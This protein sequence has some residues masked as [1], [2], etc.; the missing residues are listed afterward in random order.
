MGELLIDNRKSPEAQK[1]LD[2]KTKR[3]ERFD[4]ITREFEKRKYINNMDDFMDIA[5]NQ[6]FLA[7]EAVQVSSNPILPLEAY[8]EKFREKY[9]ENLISP[10]NIGNTL[11]I[12][13]LVAKQNNEEWLQIGDYYPKLFGSLIERI[14]DANNGR[15]TYPASDFFHLFND[16]EVMDFAISSH[17]F[18]F[19]N[20]TRYNF[21]KP[22][23][24]DTT[25]PLCRELKKFSDIVATRFAFFSS[26]ILPEPLKFIQEL[27][28]LSNKEIL[29]NL[30][31]VKE[32]YN[33]NNFEITN[34]AANCYSNFYYRE[35]MQKK[36]AQLSKE[37][38]LLINSFKE[39]GIHKGEFGKIFS[40]NL[41][42]SYTTLDNSISSKELIDKR[43]L[44][45]YFDFFIA[46]DMNIAIRNLTLIFTPENPN[47]I[48][49]RLVDLFESGNIL[50]TSHIKAE[51][52]FKRLMK[53]DLSDYEFEADYEAKE[54]RDFYKFKD[55]KVI[56]NVTIDDSLDIYGYGDRVGLWNLLGGDA[57]QKPTSFLQIYDTHR[58]L[59][60][61]DVDNLARTIL[62]FPFLLERFSEFIYPN[63]LSGE[64]DPY[65][66]EFIANRVEEFCNHLL[67]IGE[68]Y[69]FVGNLS[70]ALTNPKKFEPFHHS[71]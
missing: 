41:L 8:P 65:D 45:K 55:N 17:A 61:K 70:K 52:E 36:L 48:A 6:P 23:K 13:E 69:F 42:N 54:V 16:K 62:Q 59:V 66:N 46:H 25:E 15:N 43:D 38:D 56:V 18:C 10:E 12:F 71:G 9:S 37:P 22:A 29:E 14:S 28:S 39:L 26:S 63:I 34:L 30:K 5:K 4:E 49:S 64:T 58:S 3:N 11:R 31:N 60:N 35:E 1:Y 40:Y 24:P 20:G 2:F 27:P 68:S 47:L 57:S 44:K 53:K 50:A 32:I 67:D 21:Y 19:I 51:N 7:M 33:L